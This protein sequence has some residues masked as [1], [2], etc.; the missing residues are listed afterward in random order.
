MLMIPTDVVFP[1]RTAP[2][3]PGTMAG[4][5]AHGTATLYGWEGPS[6]AAVLQTGA[7]KR[8]FDGRNFRT[9]PLVN[10]QKTMERS[11]MIHW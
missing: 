6:A 11:T 2:G 4:A 8:W 10:I 5:L 9:Y 1:M 7:E 3:S